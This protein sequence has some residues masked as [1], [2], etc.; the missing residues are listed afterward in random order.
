LTHGPGF[1][2]LVRD[3]AA[4][5]SFEEWPATLDASGLHFTQSHPP[6]RRLELRFLLPRAPNEVRVDAE[7]VRVDREGDSFVAHVRLDALSPE[8]AAAVSRF[9]EEA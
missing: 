2:V 1:H 6:A 7:V 5:G 8:D 3:P 9:L 4:G